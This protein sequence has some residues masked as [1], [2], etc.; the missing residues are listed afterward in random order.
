MGV[1]PG[2]TWPFGSATT[3]RPSA[4]RRTGTMTMVSSPRTTTP[5]AE[6]SRLRGSRRLVSIDIAPQR[7]RVV[8]GEPSATLGDD[9]GALERGEEAAGRLAAG[10][11]ELGEVGLRGGDEDV[12]IGR[13]LGPRLVDELAEH[14]RHA[15]LHRLEALAG[16]PLVGGAQPAAQRGDE[17]DRDLGVLAHQP[18]HVGP[19]DGERLHGVDG[20]DG[21]R[22][23]LVVEHRQLAEDVA[24]AEGGEGD[25]PPVGML[26]DR[27]RVAGADDVA[28]VA[29]VALA[30]DDVAR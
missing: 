2:S 11:G 21:R 18:A 14:G 10:A 15:A 8:D 28:R 23:P 30:E 4:A 6:N 25:R 13:A 22:A 12:G 1:S 29:G 27:A 5:P 19:E 24:R 20:L 7:N 16:Q 17:L 9:A 3:L 26:A